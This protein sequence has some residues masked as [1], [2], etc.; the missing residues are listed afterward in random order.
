MNSPLSSTPRMRSSSSGISGSYCAL[1]S[2]SGI[3][4]TA[5][6]SSGPFPADHQ[7]RGGGDERSNRNVVDVT[8]DAAVARQALRRSEE[9]TSELQSRGHIVCRLLLAR[10]KHISDYK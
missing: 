5:R 9:H 6:Q 10:K 2:T 3:G 1:T 7:P 8:P 4:A